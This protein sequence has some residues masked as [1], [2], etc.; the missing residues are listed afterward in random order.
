[1]IDRMNGLRVDWWPR[2]TMSISRQPFSTL[3]LLLERRKIALVNTG[4]VV[5]GFCF[6]LLFFFLLPQRTKFVAV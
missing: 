6:F 3:R 5:T 4:P 1:M 2:K